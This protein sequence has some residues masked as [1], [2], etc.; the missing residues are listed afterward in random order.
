MQVLKTIEQFYPAIDSG[1]AKKAIEKLQC[2]VAV[3]PGSRQPR[4]R[5]VESPYFNHLE[6]AAYCNITANALYGQVER[7]RIRPL[8]VGGKNFYTREMLDKLMRGE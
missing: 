1:S 2:L 4:N 8:K 7:R 6:A 5:N 3:A